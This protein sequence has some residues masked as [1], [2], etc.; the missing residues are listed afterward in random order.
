MPEN[1]FFMKRIPILIT[2]LA[3]MLF[4][5]YT[6]AEDETLKKKN[7]S[8]TVLLARNL[9][10]PDPFDAQ[11]ALQQLFPGYY[12][13]LSSDN[14]T[15]EL[16]SWEC[17]TCTPKAC[18]DVNQVEETVFPA[19]SGVATRLINVMDFSDS[20][21]GKYKVIS[22]NHSDYDADGIQTSRFTGGIL[23]MAKFMLTPQGW[24]LRMFQPE[25]GA[26]GAFSQCPT[27]IPLLIGQDQYA[28]VI[29]HLNGGA[30]GPFNGAYFLIA[31]A[32]GAY[33]QVMAVYGVERTEGGEVE[34]NCNWKSEFR[35][36]VSDKKYFRDIIVTTKGAY[37]TSDKE[38]M[39]DEVSRRLKGKKQGTFT[40]EQTYVYK[41]SKGYEAQGEARCTVN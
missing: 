6:H 13:N 22:F 1:L 19:S 26:Y 14:Y 24:K 11:K 17:R 4:A 7:L 30:G 3:G 23:G 29:K 16:I 9:V 31:G 35:C 8:D 41:G 37:Y 25:I 39:P 38:G 28:F 18:A 32:N 12:Y 40:I 2:V 36:P 21:G 10:V 33:K 15:N 34:P 27:P 20:A 5:G